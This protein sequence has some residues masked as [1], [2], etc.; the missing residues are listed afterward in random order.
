M[1]LYEVFKV[2]KFI[3][4]VKL[5]GARIWGKERN[6]K[7]INYV[8]FYVRIIKNKLVIHSG[9]GCTTCDVLTAIELYTLK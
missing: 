3:R 7:M 6:E 2:I 8:R 5:V 1:I 9:N 4:K